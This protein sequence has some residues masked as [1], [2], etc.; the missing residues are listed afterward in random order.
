MKFRGNFLLFFSFTD[1]KTDFQKIGDLA[2]IF[3]KAHTAA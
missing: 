1:D 2:I 3:F